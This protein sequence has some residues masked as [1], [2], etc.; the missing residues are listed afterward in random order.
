MTKRLLLSLL[1]GI[2][3][4]FVASLAVLFWA[5]RTESGA[6]WLWATAVDA[7][8]DKLSARSLEGN[9][10][11]GVTLRGLRFVDPAQATG[12]ETLRFAIDIDWLGSAIDIN[13]LRADGVTVQLQAADEE[14]RS[15]GSLEQTLSALQLPVTV[16]LKD[17]Q[18]NEV[19]VIAPDGSSAVAADSVGLDATWGQALAVERVVY[20]AGSV[21]LDASALLEL[22]SPHALDVTA[23][24]ETGDAGANVGVPQHIAATLA[25]D[26]RRAN[27]AVDTR[28]PVASVR[29]TV[30]N[31]AGDIRADLRV[32]AEQFDLPL[33]A[34]DPAVS[35]REL[36][37]QVR[38]GLDAYDADLETRLLTP[39]LAAPLTVTAVVAG[40]LQSLGVARIEL[41]SEQLAANGSGD[42]RWGGDFSAAAE[43]D[44]QRL[45]PG[46]WLADWPAGQSLRGKTRLALTQSRLEVAELQ[47][48]HAA[49]S[50]ALQ[51]HGVIDTRDGIVD[52]AL[53]WQ[54]LQWPLASA[55]PNVA[56]K[57]AT[58][59]VTGVPSDWSLEGEV[60]LAAAELPAGRFILQGSGGTETFQL[61]IKDSEVLGGRLT[62]DVALDL[63]DGGSW[64]AQLASRDTRITPF[65]PG[66]PGQISADFTADGRIEPF[67]LDLVI[68]SLQGQ[69][70]GREVSAAGRMQLSRT[71]ML[72]NEFRAVTGSTTLQL[73]GDWQSDSGVAFSFASAA[74]S[75]VVPAM[76]GKAEA[77][78]RLAAGRDWPQLQLE[79]VGTDLGWRQWRAGSLELRN[80]PGGE[81]QPL[82]LALTARDIK[83]REHL[84]ES[85]ELQVNGSPAQ[86]AMSAA[87][88]QV[89]RALA[90]ALDGVLTD[91]QQAA[92]RR[93]TANVHTLDF[94]GRDEL[95]L[96]L[97]ETAEVTVSREA[98]AISTACIDSSQG[99]S[100]CAAG[101]FSPDGQYRAQ[102]DLAD[103]PLSLLRNVTGTGLQFTQSIT[104]SV[105]IATGPR[106]R[107]SGSGRLDITPG[108]INSDYDERLTLRTRPGF[109]AFELESG[110]LLAGELR[111]PFSDAAEIAASFKVVDV[112]QG[113]DS[114]VTGQL[115]AVVRDLGVGAQFLPQFDDAGGA[116][117]AD[118]RVAGTLGAPEFAGGFSVRDGRVV[119]DPLGLAVSDMQI[120]SKILPGNR[121]EVDANF[122]AGNGVGRIRSSADY[123]QG[124]SADFAVSLTGQ[125]LRLIDLPDL[126]VIVN[127]DLEVGVSGDDISINGKLVVPAARLA[128][129]KFVN[130][131]VSE[132]E[133]VVY[134]GEI[135]P[136][137]AAPERAPSPLNYRGSVVLELGADV[138]IDLDVA[139]AKI[140][141]SSTYRWD[142]PA[143]PRATGNFN[144]SGKF[145]AYGQLLEISEGSIRY[146]NMPANNPL[147]RIRA[148]R[149][150]F[151]NSQVRRAGVFVTGT[152]LKPKLEVFTTPATTPD[153]ALTLLVTG[154]D[155][156]YEQ[157]V[158]AVDVGTYVAP[159]LYASYGIGLFDRE[160]V[161]S[162]RYDLAKGFGIK[163]TS[164]KRAAGIDIS[165]TIER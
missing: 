92:R 159:R 68:S 66:W 156:S 154:S 63:R 104:G 106:G 84:F 70:R 127:P 105:E 18:L 147:L 77:Q 17:L 40:D 120:S 49:G 59:R 89:D 94:G 82:G 55:A 43:L 20:R 46:A 15:T 56:S 117:D 121:I 152:A 11:D 27:L 149:E 112:S 157:G 158:G 98:A 115:T 113:Q 5:L 67:A 81:A 72:F 141:G 74:L 24:L 78:G 26:L 29:G 146:P 137:G 129:V 44:V 33:A 32:T 123:L 151:G 90:L 62:G 9:L 145:E 31:L 163:A 76:T 14:H 162:V 16:R 79:L 80:E 140:R 130:T 60:A 96:A 99:G 139:E 155:F 133:D 153:R 25:G 136:E 102:L 61:A 71:Q 150:I 8:P 164:G 53:D 86:H 13:A 103:M 148:E 128:S 135:Q 42:V 142:G 4:V 83:L 122:R 114:P 124:L 85:A 97:R 58:L 36:Q 37:L 75:D 34:T 22:S 1:I 116:L 101:Q 64:S 57:A 118:I 47:L 131:G 161:I 134:V 107:P 45:D 125:N 7:L 144:V 51:A 39:H 50:A 132:S 95:K 165:Y 52:L 110:Q 69:V 87:L 93:W 38:G 65:L 100:L 21:R 10:S 28:M 108:V 91:W 88:T 12:V 119:Y 73:D 41:L 2:V 35:L 160:N 126:R 30:T 3:A 109:A 138:A 23:Q 48:S 54:D 143:L 19:R 111:L 6:T